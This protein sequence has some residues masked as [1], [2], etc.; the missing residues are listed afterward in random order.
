M[1]FLWPA[2]LLSLLSVP[3]LVLGYLRIQKRRQ[4]QI[5]NFARFDPALVARKRNPGFNKHIPPLL[6][7]AGLVVLLVALARPQAQ[8]SLPRVEGTVMLVFDVSGSMA[9]TDVEPSRIEA[10]RTAAKE[11][12]LS[13]PQTVQIG[14]VSFSTSGLTVQAPTNDT[15]SLTTAIDRLQPQTGTSLGQGILAALH[16]IAVYNGLEPVVLP[17]PDEAAQQEEEGQ[18]A[19]GEG[20]I[21]A[22]LPEGPYPAA[23]I[24]L[25]SDGED[26]MSINPLEAAQAA[27][28]REVRIDAL[29]FGTTAGSVLELEGYSVFTALNEAMLQQ[30]TQIAEGT[31]F[32]PQNE[33][34]PQA[35]YANL[36]PALVIK[37]EMMEITSVLTGASLLIL[38]AG[39]VLSML[40]FNR[41]P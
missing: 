9:A 36:T 34:D 4:A 3:L 29:G 28:E 41:L 12:I 7:L 21:L 39:A 11:F 20:S 15:L 38:F 22:Q 35:V 23:V 18:P 27:A 30:I 5:A 10:A 33:P 32:N 1:T 16:T 2:M 19:F 13:Q 25:L 26:N 24:V 14:I 40:W 37:P 6:M 17:T 8:I 31:Y